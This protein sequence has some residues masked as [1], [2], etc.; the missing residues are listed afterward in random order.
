MLFTAVK[1]LAA[2][3]ALSDGVSKLD[4]HFLFALMDDETHFWIA[5]ST[6]PR[7][8]SLIGFISEG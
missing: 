3:S 7:G 1:T 4:I 5:Y 2:Y 6:S 8:Y